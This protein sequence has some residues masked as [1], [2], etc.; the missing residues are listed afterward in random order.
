[1]NNTLIRICREG[2]GMEPAAVQALLAQTSWAADRSQAVIE[3]SLRN[4][5]CCGAFLPDSGR[6][7]GFARVITDYATSYYLCDVVVDRAFRRRG[8]GSAMI[9]ALTAEPALAELQGLLITADAQRLYL[10]YGFRPA[11]ICFMVKGKF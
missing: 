6:Q 11:D 1:M 9:V 7:I 2:R 10:P 8:I 4:S 5:L 3:V